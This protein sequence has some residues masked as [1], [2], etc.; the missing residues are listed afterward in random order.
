VFYIKT[1]YKNQQEVAEAINNTIDSY[2]KNDTEDEEMIRQIKFIA[3]N[4]DSLL[5]KDGD[6]TTLIKQR[7]GKRRLEIVN[8]ILL[9]NE[10]QQK[11]E[12]K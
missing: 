10:T 3:R 9:L 4:N 12:G 7:C 11:M 1:F 5:F 6:Y 8:K 2:W